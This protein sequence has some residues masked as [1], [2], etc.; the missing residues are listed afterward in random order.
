MR[1]QGQLRTAGMGGVIGLDL[2]AVLQLAHTLGYDETAMAELLPYAERG[3][4]TAINART[5]HDG[6]QDPLDQTQRR[7]R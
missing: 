5:P 4:V 2:S 1:C 7:G 3:M 6:D